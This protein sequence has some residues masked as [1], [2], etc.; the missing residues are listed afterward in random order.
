DSTIGAGTVL[1]P[2]GGKYQL[3]PAEGMV[4]KIPVL[5]GDTNTATIMTHG[6][7]PRIAKWSPF[8][9]AVYAIVEALAKLTAMGGDYRKVR[10]TFQE[11]FERLGDDPKKWGKPFSALLGAYRAQMELGIPSI[12]GKDSMSGTF[13]DLTVPPTLVAF[14]VGVLDVRDVVSPEFKK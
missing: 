11:Y 5:E 1:M 7:N 4:A 8:H 14:A 3:T 9:G 10:M 13:E 6:Y 12:G 2:F